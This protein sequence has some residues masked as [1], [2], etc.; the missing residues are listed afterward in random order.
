MKFSRSVRAAIVVAFGMLST[1]ALADN[2]PSRTIHLI[3]PYPPGGT[4]DIL[5]RAIGQELSRSLG[6]SV[7]VD[8]RTGAGGIVGHDAAAKATPDGYTLVL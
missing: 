8:N 4:T 5:A 2:Y 7:V 3:S 6:Q 1:A